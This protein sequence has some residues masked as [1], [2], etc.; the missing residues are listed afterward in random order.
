MTGDSSLPHFLS[1]GFVT[2]NFPLSHNIE[3]PMAQEGG[4]VFIYYRNFDS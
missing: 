3:I 2:K 4:D 1:D